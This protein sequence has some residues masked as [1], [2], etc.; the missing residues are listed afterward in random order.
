MKHFAKLTTG[1]GNNAIVMGRKT[2]ESLP[3]GPLPKRDNIVMSRSLEKIE[4]GWVYSSLEEVINH[5]TERKYEK[6]WVIGGAQIYNIFLEK[7][8]IQEIYKTVIPG[9]YECDCFFPDEPLKKT[10]M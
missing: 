5:C 10:F 7:K 3:H 2:W 6:V 4:G 1:S 8:I 9:D